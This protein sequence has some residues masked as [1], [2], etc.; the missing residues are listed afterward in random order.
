MVIP[1]SMA[2]ARARPR[3][4]GVAAAGCIAALLGAAGQARAFQPPSLTGPT[5]LGGTLIGGV[6]APRTFTATNTS[7]VP[8]DQASWA[9]TSETGLWTS[10]GSFGCPV[11]DVDGKVPPGAACT[12]DLLPR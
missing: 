7:A 11:L 1:S 10:G 2:G 8:V 5:D 6:E 12:L 9:L 3:L 4:V